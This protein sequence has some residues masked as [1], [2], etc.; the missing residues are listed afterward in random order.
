MTV[1]TDAKARE[2]CAQ[3]NAKLAPH[4]PDPAWLKDRMASVNPPCNPNDT[5]MTIRDFWQWSKAH[6]KTYKVD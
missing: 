1:R 6:S 2:I 4:A 3:A 5:P